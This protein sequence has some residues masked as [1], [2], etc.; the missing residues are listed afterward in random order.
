MNG[1]SRR[2]MFCAKVGGALGRNLIASAILCS[3]AVADETAPPHVRFAGRVVDTRCFPIEGATVTLRMRHT[4]DRSTVTGADGH[5]EIDLGPHRDD[6]ERMV[7]IHVT[8]GTG[9]AALRQWRLWKLDW[10]RHA[11][12][13]FLNHHGHG[14]IDLGTFVPRTAYPLLV[15]VLREGQPVGG[16][17]VRVIWGRDRI[18]AERRITASDGRIT[19]RNLPRG[20]VVV[21]A[22]TDGFHGQLEADVPL[23]EDSPFSEAW[24]IEVELL[25]TWGCTIQTISA[26]DETPITG[27]YVEIFE[28]PPRPPGARR[29]MLLHGERPYLRRL[30]E[31]REVTDPSGRIRIEGLGRQQRIFVR[32]FGGPDYRTTSRGLRKYGNAQ[33]EVPTDTEVTTLRLWPLNPGVTRY[34]ILSSE[35][36]RDHEGE[37][38][39]TTGGLERVSRAVSA[40][41]EDNRVIWLYEGH[42]YPSLVEAGDGCLSAI[43]GSNDSVHFVRPRRL[44]VR[45]TDSTGTPVPHIWVRAKSRLSEALVETDAFGLADLEGLLA[46]EHEISVLRPTW[47]YFSEL[48]SAD[49]TSGDTEVSLPLPDTVPVTLRV[50]IDGRPGLPGG[51]ELTTSVRGHRFFD[52]TAIHEDPLAGTLQFEMLPKEDT[53]LFTLQAEGF[54]SGECFVHDFPAEG[55]EVPVELHEH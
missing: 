6:V 35:C 49:M 16:A 43:G 44:R 15:R 50:Q 31:R 30:Q 20:R 13:T 19:F 52:R 23:L 29:E 14:R 45:I 5:F 42:I 47:Q 46:E 12:R 41:I 39:I 55:V 4:A 27:P 3:L 37:A 11:Q 1:S 17:E 28:D 8:D 24:E 36:G 21:E 26:V 32:Y 18:L 34:R 54:A 40:H 33:K 25:P 9:R 7:G 10:H 53:V 2:F 22:R 48:E 38:S 51:Y